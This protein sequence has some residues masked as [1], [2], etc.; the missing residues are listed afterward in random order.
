MLSYRAAVPFLARTFITSGMSFQ[1]DNLLM[2]PALPEF[3]K[4]AETGLTAPMLQELMA[5]K[6]L[7]RRSTL[8]IHA[9]ANT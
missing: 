5:P 6:L 2:P 7:G 9:Q 8:D 1:C 4:L 3:Q